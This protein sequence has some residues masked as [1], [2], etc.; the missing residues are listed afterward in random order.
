MFWVEK[1]RP[2]KD[3]MKMAQFWKAHAR[4]FHLDEEEIIVDQL[5]I[6]FLDIEWRSTV[7]EVLFE[8]IANKQKDEYGT[9]SSFKNYYILQCTKE[10]F[11][12]FSLSFQTGTM[13]VQFDPEQILYCNYDNFC[14]LD[15]ERSINVV[16]NRI[17]YQINLGHLAHQT[18]AF[19]LH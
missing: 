10:V 2:Q 12:N 19:D 4:S 9:V 16:Q 7:S 14:V 6:L 15:I 1:T 18:F 17:F 8:R 3:E 5:T 13:F 11:F